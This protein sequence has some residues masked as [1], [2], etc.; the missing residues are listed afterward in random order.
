[1]GIEDLD[2]LVALPLAH[3]RATDLARM[4]CTSRLLR[5]AASDD[6]LW[7][8]LY[9][10]D[11]DRSE[12]NISSQR[13]ESPNPQHHRTMYLKLVSMHACSLCRQTMWRACS[14]AS[15]PHDPPDQPGAAPLPHYRC[16]C[17]PFRTRAPLILVA[18]DETR[19]ED[20]FATWE[21]F[22]AM[23]ARLSAAFAATWRSVPRLTDAALAGAHLVLLL[24][25]R[26]STPPLTVSRRAPFDDP[27][28]RQL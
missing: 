13:D 25:V 9:Y 28:P 16:P 12:T 11:F 15:L 6:S 7:K 3:C 22:S 4:M 24:I 26:L 18:L 8:S 2:D 1:M 27:K 14:A 17:V 10:Q 21:H 23:R 20:P 19:V 5:S